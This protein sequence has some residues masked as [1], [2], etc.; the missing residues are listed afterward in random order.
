MEEKTNK[1]Q[2]AQNSQAI[3]GK[4]KI[5]SQNVASNTVKSAL[6]SV[7]GK[8]KDGKKNASF[9]RIWFSQYYR[10]VS[11]SFAAVIFAFFFMFVSYPKISSVGSLKKDAVPKVLSEQENLNKQLDYLVKAQKAKYA[12][13]EVDIQNIEKTIPTDPNT[14]QIF[15][16]LEGISKEV[17]V[18][19]G[20][21]NFS[22]LDAPKDGPSVT[23]SMEDGDSFGGEDVSRSD[24]F[25]ISMIEI[26]LSVSSGPYDEFKNFLDKVE[27]N[28]RLMDIVSLSYSPSGESYGLT[29]RS[30]YMPKQ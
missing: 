14:P 7:F 3:S 1:K 26:S 19:I 13:S 2:N 24:D 20:T 8:K 21:I 12:I 11:Y 16:T 10:I 29:L 23:P 5:V 28:M 25:G 17:G 4:A 27:K 9:M 30:Y 6:E 15:T 18:T 22:L